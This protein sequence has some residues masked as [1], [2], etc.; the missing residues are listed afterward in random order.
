MQTWP[1]KSLRAS[2]ALLLAVL[3]LAAAAST[4]DA[5]ILIGQSVGGVQL[6]ATKAQVD[7][8]LGG[9]GSLSGSERLW[10][11]ARLRV[12][13]VHGNAD[14]ILSGSKRQKTESGV[15]VGST[16]AQVRS[17]YPR[18][19][20]QKGH[21]PGPLYLYC[22][23]AGHFQGRATYTGFLSESPTGGVVEVELGFGSVAQA[24]KHP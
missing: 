9:A 22:V 21:E 6:G 20:C 4:A 13:F 7:R 16:S 3:T 18:A 10:E 24:L 15:G 1:S 23:V 12:K 11:S 8:T 2:S 19:T 5:R 14:Q 17:A